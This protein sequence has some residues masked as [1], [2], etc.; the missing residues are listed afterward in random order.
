MSTMMSSRPASCGPSHVD[1]MSMTPHPPDS[2][3]QRYFVPV[4]ISFSTTGKVLMLFLP[5]FPLY[6]LSIVDVSC[7][8]GLGRSLEARNAGFVLLARLFHPFPVHCYLDGPWFLKSSTFPQDQPANHLSPW[9]PYFCHCHRASP[10]CP[11]AALYLF[12]VVLLVY[13]P[14][15]QTY[16]LLTL[17]QSEYPLYLFGSYFYCPYSRWINDRASS[18]FSA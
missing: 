13:L 18:C 2:C 9:L 6:L 3:L 14:T 12:F 1:L 17:V 4:I 10:C 16:Q 7:P 15:F 8:L 5:S 11:S